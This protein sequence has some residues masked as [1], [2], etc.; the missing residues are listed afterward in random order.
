VRSLRRFL[1]KSEDSGEFLKRA[2][3][4]HPLS[5]PTHRRRETHFFFFFHPAGRHQTESPLF[6]AAV[7]VM[8]P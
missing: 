4:V 3:L 5:T 8:T 7:T 1:E 6:I 2:K